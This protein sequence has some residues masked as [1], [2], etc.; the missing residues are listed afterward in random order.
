MIEEQNQPEEM[1]PLENYDFQEENQGK[2]TIDNVEKK[3]NARK[4]WTPLYLAIAFLWALRLHSICYLQSQVR[5]QINNYRSL[6][7]FPIY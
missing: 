4:I 2:E 7:K 5:F 1:Q 6:M 3:K